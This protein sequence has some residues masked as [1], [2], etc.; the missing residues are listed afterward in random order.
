MTLSQRTT[1]P[2]ASTSRSRRGRLLHPRLAVGALFGA[3]VMVVHQPTLSSL[4]RTLPQN[5][6]DP[7]LT[8]WIMAW[9]WHSVTTGPLSFFDANIFHPSDSIIGYSEMLLPHLVV[10]GP[11]YALTGNPVLAHNVTILAL[12]YLSLVATYHLAMRLVGSRDVAVLAAIAYSA[13]GYVLKHQG[14]IQLLALGLF[15]LAFLCLFHVLERGR[16]RDG[17]FLGLATVALA[18]GC[19]YYGANWFLCMGTIVVAALIHRR[20]DGAWLTLLRPL[21]V[22][23]I[24]T[25]VLLGPIAYKYYTFQ[26]AVGFQRPLSEQSGLEAKDFL[27]PAEGTRFY[28]G[29][30]GW[31]SAGRP[32]AVEHTFF[33]G[34]AV[35]ALAVAG[36]VVLASG[37][38]RRAHRRKRATA[39]LARREFALMGWAVAVS[40]VVALGPRALGIPLPFR[41]LYD[42][43]PG[44]DGMQAIS[45][46]A[47]PA[48]LALAVLAAAGLDRL[49]TGLPTR[50]RV[51]ACAVVAL[52]TI[53]ELSVTPDRVPV[54][55][56]NRQV[57]AALADAG[58]GPVIELPIRGTGPGKIVPFV[59]GPRMLA[60]VGD[61]RPRVNGFSG[62]FP[63]EYLANAQV[64]NRFPEP[65][66]LALLHNQ[67][68]RFVVLHGSDHG[69]EFAYD[70]A[71]LS[72]LVAALAP[73]FVATRYGEDY[74]VDLGGR[75]D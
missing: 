10:F 48:M 32:D 31:A 54:D 39:A 52:L 66:A 68:V 43:V 16:A 75:A 60:S 6:G 13:S 74:L 62:G 23:G 42:Y 11:I 47:V 63:A 9:G 59:E 22:A 30:F 2:Q 26:Q 58:P 70:T 7:A 40:L 56:S 3:V 72:G 67:G 19:L 1:A 41:V 27:L 45:R 53:A 17:L 28:S 65:D 5:L 46:F 37:H 14:H 69:E 18:T 49:L 50:L 34:F 35:T 33:P 25:A 20:R 71:T 73:E 57:Y 44:F 36:V 64:F 15:P 8:T 29:L 38:R 24:V 61:W 55:E 4:R 12:S 21:T 51:P